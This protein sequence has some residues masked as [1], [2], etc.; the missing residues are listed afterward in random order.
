[1]NAKGET[2]ATIERTIEK[3]PGHESVRERSAERATIS[4]PET[5]A[6]LT[7]DNSSSPSIEFDVT[8]SSTLS[9]SAG[10]LGQMVVAKI[11][12]PWSQDDKGRE[13]DTAFELRGSDLV[14]IVTPSAETAYPIVSD[15]RVVWMGYYAQLWYTKAETQHMR[16]SGVVIAGMLAT[17]A[18]LAAFGPPG[19]A[20]GAAMFAIG[21]AMFA[22]GAG[23]AGIIAATAANAVDDGKC[24]KVDVPS[25]YPSIVKC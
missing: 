19:A 18:G 13:V 17:G 6:E 9:I 23:A 15:P 11:D 22:I 21:A 8:G 24:L 25:M 2:N 12:A 20:V 4:I 3:A 16:D 7:V 5:G 1:M 14:Q 10:G